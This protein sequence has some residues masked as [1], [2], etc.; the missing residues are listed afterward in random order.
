VLLKFGLRHQ[1]LNL[2]GMPSELFP[3]VWHLME[4]LKEYSLEILIQLKGLITLYIEHFEDKNLHNVISLYM[5]NN[6]A[7][8]YGVEEFVKN[9]SLL[10]VSQYLSEENQSIN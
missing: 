10:L 2:P 3:F 7:L 1:I 5:C 6:P 9:N 4:F 8:A